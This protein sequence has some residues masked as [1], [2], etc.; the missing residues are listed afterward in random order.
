MPKTNLISAIGTPLNP[1]ESLH[2][3]GLERML[4]LQWNAGI[5]GVLV[6]GTMGLLQLLRDQT[7]AQ[8]VEHGVRIWKGKGEI[9]VGVGDAGFARTADRI[10][11]VNRFAVDGVVALSPYLVRFRQEELLDYFL[12]LA[13]I[14]KAPLFL[15]DLPSFTGVKLE[16][17]TV[18]AL[19][20]HPNIAGIKFS[21]NLNDALDLIGSVEPNFRVIVAQADQV[22]ALCDQG[23]INQLDGVFSLV[24]EWTREIANASE[25]GDWDSAKRAQQQVSG[26]LNLLREYGVFPAYHELIHVRDIPGLFAPKPFQLLSGAKLVALM[27]HPL[28]G[29]LSLASRELADR[30]A[31]RAAGGRE[32]AKTDG[33][34]ARSKANFQAS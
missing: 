21:G 9:L 25:S 3:A 5:D 18:F 1:D 27:S 34:A 31:Q 12:A 23:I 32:F 16:V 4:S 29:S 19:S 13:N 30:G 2:L 26:V 7:Y 14:S 11:Y 28:V 24:P 10:D 20:K 22:D 8:L 17:A 15:Y 33:A 6:A